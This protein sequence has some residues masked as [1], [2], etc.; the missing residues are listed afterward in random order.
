M[1]GG[2]GAAFHILQLDR[3][4][5]AD[6]SDLDAECR[7][8]RTNLAPLILSLDRRAG[9]PPPV[10][11][12]WPLCLQMLF[13]VFYI[14]LL[15]DS[16]KPCAEYRAR[17]CLPQVLRCIRCKQ[18]TI[19][20][21]SLRSIKLNPQCCQ[22][23]WILQLKWKA[24]RSTHVTNR[25]HTPPLDA[26]NIPPCEISSEKTQFFTLLL[27]A[28]AVVPLKYKK[29]MTRE[30]RLKSRASQLQ[31]RENYVQIPLWAL[32]QLQ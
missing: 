23:L 24:T 8:K 27:S 6:Y 19:S 5:T 30:G 17:L 21:Y 1:A 13:V 7:A 26:R 18:I 9:A 11:R 22:I 4:R 25:L 12:L 31:R 16:A 2:T 3:R 32:L 20:I 10:Q 28:S 14:Y 29:H 15:I